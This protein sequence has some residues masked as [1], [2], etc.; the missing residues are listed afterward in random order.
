MTILMRTHSVP[1][2][3]A[4]GQ[5]AM[6]DHQHRLLRGLYETYLLYLRHDLLLLSLFLH[7]FLSRF[8][9]ISKESILVTLMT[10]TCLVL[11]T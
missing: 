6:F 7:G 4:Q 1:S 8:I 2:F 9:D 10:Q 11:T 3:H 5:L